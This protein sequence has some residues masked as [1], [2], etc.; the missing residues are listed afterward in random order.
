MKKNELFVISLVVFLTIVA[1]VII[2]IYHIQE[3]I[4]DQINIKPVTIPDYQM[5]EQVISVL[6]EKSE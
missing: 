2:D 6:K 5:D 3:K 4:N 1:W